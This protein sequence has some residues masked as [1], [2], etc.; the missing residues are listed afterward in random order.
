MADVIV[1]TEAIT[2]V[3]KSKPVVRDLKIKYDP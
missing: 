3:L 2:K 1:S